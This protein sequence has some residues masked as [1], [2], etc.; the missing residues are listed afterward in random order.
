[1]VY[2]SI[3]GSLLLSTVEDASPAER[4]LPMPLGHCPRGIVL[5]R[6]PDV[7]LVL[8][9]ILHVVYCGRA[10]AMPLGHLMPSTGKVASPADNVVAVPLG[11]CPRGTVL[12]RKPG[13]VMVLSD[14]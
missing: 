1:M 3:S 9:L 7:V 2:S 13:L 4:K 12:L 5:L 14:W 8:T 10:V 11:H 6:K